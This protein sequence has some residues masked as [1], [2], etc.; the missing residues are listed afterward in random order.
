MP[1]LVGGLLALV[2]N[3]LAWPISALTRRHY[4]VAY[5]LK[6][7]EARAHRLVRV[8]S[9]AASV[10]FIGWATVALTVLSKL[11]SRLTVWVIL[12]DIL[13]PFAFVGGAA[14]GLWSAW[15]VLRGQRRWFAKAWSV[16]LAA[17][18]LTV[19]WA[20]VAFH[21]IAFRTVF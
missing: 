5:G 15:V 4:R 1:L 16:V 7:S 10:V 20:A 11:D 13:A 3:S 2:L 12:L 18:L 8:A 17:A 6:G 21:L 14:A 19:L 9:V